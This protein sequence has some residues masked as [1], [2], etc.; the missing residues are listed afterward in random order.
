MRSML[1]LVVVLVLLS[2]NDS[3]SAVRLADVGFEVS[4][5]AGDISPTDLNDIIAVM[6]IADP[7]TVVYGLGAAALLP[8][9]QRLRV[10]VGSGYYRAKSGEG[11]IQIFASP[12]P[13]GYPT[14]TEFQ[15]ESVPLRGMVDVTLTDRSPV[16]TLGAALEMHFM[17]L[18][19]T[20]D[21]VPALGFPG[22]EQHSSANIPG[23]SVTAG[24]EWA[25]GQRVFMGFGGGYRFAKGDVPLFQFPTDIRLDLSGP[26]AMMLIRV[27]PWLIGGKDQ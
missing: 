6:G 16:L 11:S 12:S 5:L 4:G 25:V 3:R 13:T 1:A 14:T 18:T 24:V 15:V 26:F 19:R 2:P 23:L 17:S 8:V 20:I 21:E 22:D 27:H 9:T 10:S 7:M